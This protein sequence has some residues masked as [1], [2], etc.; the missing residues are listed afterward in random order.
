MQ[1]QTL[2]YTLANGVAVITMNRPEKMNALTTQMRADLS[3]AVTEAGKAARVVVLTH[4]FKRDLTSRGINPD[5]VFVVTNG[6]EV[7]KKDGLT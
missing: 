6:I 2:T 1:Y 7:E 3:F 4:S 5:K